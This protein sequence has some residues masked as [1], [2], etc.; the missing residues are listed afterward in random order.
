MM[1]VYLISSLPFPHQHYVGITTNL[2]QRLSY[3]NSGQSV[4]TAKYAPWRIE[5]AIAF[6]S[7]E[8]AIDFERYLKSH[9]GHAFAAKHF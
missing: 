9:S 8:K 3:H 6:R 4:H 1:Y 5:A 7:R 2:T